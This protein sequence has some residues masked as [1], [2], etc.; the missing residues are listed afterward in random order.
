[1][2]RRLE[3]FQFARLLS[4]PHDGKPAILLDPDAVP[5]A[6]TLAGR[7]RAAARGRRNPLAAIARRFVG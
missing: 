1:M 6:W 3:I 5:S 4:L 2:H 7:V